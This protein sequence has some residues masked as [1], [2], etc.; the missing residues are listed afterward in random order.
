[1]LIALN[2]L[3]PTTGV[4]GSHH[5]SRHAALWNPLAED[6]NPA[7]WLAPDETTISN[8][9]GQGIQPTP[10]LVCS[11]GT[12]SRCA[13]DDLWTLDLRPQHRQLLI[14]A[15]GKD[16]EIGA[17]LTM[18]EVLQALQ[19]QGRSIPV[20][21]SS[22]PGCGFILTGG[23]GPL[24]RSQGLALDQ[25]VGMRGVWGNGTTFDMALPRHDPA[26]LSA[27]DRGPCY[28][29]EW[30]GLLGAAPFLAVVTAI[31]LRTQ[32]LKPLAVWRGVCSTQQLAMAIEI[33]EQWPHGASLQ[34]AWSERIEIFVV[35]CADDSAA[36]NA[37]ERLRRLL[38]NSADSCLTMVPG[39]HAQPEF[40]TLARSGSVM[41]RIHREV[42][43]RLGPGWGQR[44]PELIAELNQLIRDRPHPGCQ[45]S[46]QQLGAKSAQVPVESTSFIHRAAIWK[47]W[48]SAVWNANDQE[49]RERAL[50]WLD[51]AN[52]FL[53][54]WCPGVHLAQIHPH[55]SCHQQELDEAFADWLP[56][57]KQLKAKLDPNGNLPAL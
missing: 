6:S 35:C 10:V 53:T 27:I 21:L 18:A 54:Q 48:I 3:A 25:V 32:V 56:G 28:G 5:V 22:I 39:Q 57:L 46:A 15:D 4:H 45:I 13:A 38:G 1:M 50:H 9:L 7:G 47:P 37:M 33:A 41:G 42:I 19:R 17:G 52:T 31:R 34:W 30:R 16:V 26:Q 20:G 51:Q 8:L 29:Q 24:S 55:L 40:G 44:T 43:S 49:G 23:V 11:G 12:S 2:G 36:M 14:S